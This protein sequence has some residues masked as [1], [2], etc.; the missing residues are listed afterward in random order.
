MYVG[1][2]DMYTR[3]CSCESKGGYNHSRVN[4]P[5]VQHK[6]SIVYYRIDKPKHDNTTVKH[7]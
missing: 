4:L 2:R 3:D 5:H 6:E 7:G 1:H